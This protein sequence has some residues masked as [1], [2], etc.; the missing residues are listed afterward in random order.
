MKKRLPSL[1]EEIVQ[2]L[3]LNEDRLKSKGGIWM[4]Y[5][6]VNKTLKYNAARWGQCRRYSLQRSP[7]SASPKREE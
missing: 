6:N 2:G 5:E 1:A 4:K 7:Y 3:E